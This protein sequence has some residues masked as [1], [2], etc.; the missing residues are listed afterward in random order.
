MVSD[1]FYVGA[2]ARRSCTCTCVRMIVRECN[3]YLTAG[4][5]KIMSSVTRPIIYL[6][7]KFCLAMPQD[8]PIYCHKI[9]LLSVH[10][11]T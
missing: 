8:G 4:R 9:R 7:N 5:H 11:C 6:K 1:G 3:W 2:Q 10:G